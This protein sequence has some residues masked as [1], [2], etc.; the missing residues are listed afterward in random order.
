MPMS[1]KAYK[2]TKEEVLAWVQVV[3]TSHSTGGQRPELFA[4]EV[5]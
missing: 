3:S 2:E 1:S 5:V 4:L